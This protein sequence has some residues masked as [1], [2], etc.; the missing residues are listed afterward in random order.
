MCEPVLFARVKTAFG[1]TA[2]QI[3]EKQGR[4]NVLVG[5]VGSA[6]SEAELAMLMQAAQDKLHPGS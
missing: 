2:V 5:H 4:R 6:H 1:A 3:M